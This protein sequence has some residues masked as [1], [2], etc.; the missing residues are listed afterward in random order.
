MKDHPPTLK[1]VIRYYRKLIKSDRDFLTTIQQTCQNEIDFLKSKN[2]EFTG[3]FK[4][5]EEIKNQA[6][7]LLFTHELSAV[8]FAEDMSEE[9]PKG[10]MELPMTG[11]S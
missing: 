8:K 2:L 7:K 9:I 10:Q 6:D 5:F 1:K 3:S 11:V 4:A